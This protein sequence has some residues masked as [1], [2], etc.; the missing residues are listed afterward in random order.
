SAS[1]TGIL[2]KMLEPDPDRR[3]SRL[4]LILPRA[5]T[6]S[7]VEAKR[8]RASARVEPVSGDPHQVSMNEFFRSAA[9]HSSRRERQRA[10]RDAR[11]EE[12][13]ARRARRFER[14]RNE[15]GLPWPISL[16]LSLALSLGILSV[17]MATQVVVPLLLM[18][19]S[20]I[21]ARQSLQRAAQRVRVAGRDA[22]ENMNRSRRWMSG[23]VSAADEAEEREPMRVDADAQRVRV[24]EVASPRVRVDEEDEEQSD[25][26]APPTRSSNK[27]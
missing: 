13:A 17:A 23:D 20:V 16:F 24:A 26:H 27:R 5:Q 4:S 7:R 21:F 3:A 6:S 14:R 9:E 10:K 2:E 18:F 15:Y 19:L 1:L 11:R 8:A 22:I 12:R 25:E